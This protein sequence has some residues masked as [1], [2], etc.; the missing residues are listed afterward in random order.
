MKLLN[1]TLSYLSIIFFLVIG[2]WATLLYVNLLDEIYDSI[3]D[4]LG[5]SKILIIQK[6]KVDS[7]IFDK[8]NFME[9]N[10]AI[11]EI[12]AKR[13]TGYRDV[14]I[15]SLF[16]M[17]NEE[18]YEP[19]RILKT[20]FQGKHGKYY[21]LHIVSS[22]VEEDDLIEDLSWS[23]LW[24]YLILL[25]SILVINNVLLNRIWKPFYRIVDQLK[26]FS[27]E[28]KEP[29]RMPTTQVTEFRL[30]GESVTALL[31]RTLSSFN[32]QKQ[33][34]ENASHEL[35]TP[36]AISIN[37][38]ELFAEKRATNESELKE[39]SSVIE[40]LERLTRLNKALL[41]LSKIDNHQFAEQTPVDINQVVTKVVSELADLAEHRYVTLTVQH[42]GQLVQTM[43]AELAS[44]MIFNLLKNAIVH[45]V[46]GGNVSVTITNQE[47]K[48]ENTSAVGALDESLIFQRFYKSSS[49]ESSVGLGLAIV[50]AIA[51]YYDWKITYSFT[52]H[53]VFLLRFNRHGN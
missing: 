27:I 19:V 33:F 23:I 3:D 48:I 46:S 26:R 17:L 7:T 49:N 51:G 42:T 50:K 28:S 41:L 6:A 15:D 44:I 16:Y 1:Y 39:I 38:L 20:A 21:E 8:T 18:D 24:L 47:L 2:V 5:N 31:E 9:S 37:R 22:M 10:Y 25:A 14:Y 53:H 35:Q 52:N 29:F 32:S 12:D 43:N 4:G 30:L 13:A 45:N 40:T 11:R 36:L 34:I